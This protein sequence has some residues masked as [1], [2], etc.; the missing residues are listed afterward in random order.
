MAERLETRLAELAREVEYPPTPELAAAVRARVAAQAPRRRRWVPRS[1]RA[2]VL[3]VSLALL[4][5]TGAAAA[6]PGVRHAIGDLLG[7]RGATVQRVPTTPRTPAVAG[8]DLGPRV[9]L[10]AAARG[11]GFDLL[12]PRDRALGAP[13]SVHLAAGARVTLVYPSATL[14]QARGS[15][16]LDVV[17]KLTPPSTPIRRVRVNGEPGLYVDGPHAVMFSDANGRIVVDRARSTGP[18]LL[19]QQGPLLLRLEAD[20]G[21]ARALQIARS[22]R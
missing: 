12:L 18:A 3:A 21:Q 15:T 1:R 8:R 17:R 2:L 10:A 5:A 20:V 19:W 11:A 7:L 14:T 13:E 4:G 6:I 16:A 22:V 9:T